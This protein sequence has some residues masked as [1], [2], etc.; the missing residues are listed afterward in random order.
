M[1]RFSARL[2]PRMV[3]LLLLPVIVAAGC[4]H[5][6]LVTSDPPGLPVTW[7][8]AAVGVT[9]LAVED[10]EAFALNR[11]QVGESVTSVTRLV[12]A[13]RAFARTGVAALALPLNG[14][15]LLAGP[16]VATFLLPVSALVTAWASVGTPDRVH[17]VRALSGQPIG[18]G[19]E[20]PPFALEYLSGDA[21]FPAGTEVGTAVV[22]GSKVRYITERRP[23]AFSLNYLGIDFQRDVFG[24]DPYLSTGLELEWLPMPRLGIGAGLSRTIV[25]GYLEDERFLVDDGTGERTRLSEWRAGLFSRYRQPL[26]HWDGVTGGLDATASLGAEV[27]WQQITG[28]LALRRALLL[29]YGEAG[30]D[31]QITLPVVLFAALRY[32]PD[33]SGETTRRFV[34][35]TRLNVGMRVLF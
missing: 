14:V 27:A 31:A 20:E 32:Y 11:L 16:T 18:E 12:P 1:R 17:V 29:P 5:R 22:D 30:L 9:P 35:A 4:T 33:T 24:S 3:G 23:F 34:P 7:N 10:D 21:V 25:R 2:L 6:M 13:D 26:L 8:G 28:A 15:F 19:V